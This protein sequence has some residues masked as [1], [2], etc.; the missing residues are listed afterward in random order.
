MSVCRSV[1]LLPDKASLMMT[2]HGRISL[3]IISLTFLVVFYFHSSCVWF[4]PR[5]LGYPVSS[6]WS[7]RHCWVSTSCHGV[8]LNLNQI[9]VSHSPKFHAITAPEYLV[10]RKICASKLLW[11]VLCP[12]FFFSSLPSSIKETRKRTERRQL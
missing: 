12:C 2:R 11:L 9:L 8:I 4:Y 1:H 3:E 7:S 5:S 10:G 6:Y